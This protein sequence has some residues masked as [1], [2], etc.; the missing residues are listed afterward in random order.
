MSEQVGPEGA[1]ALRD[2]CV[3][4]DYDGPSEILY[5]NGSVIAFAPIDPVTDGHLLVVPCEHVPHFGSDPDVSMEV[6]EFAA[7]LV[8][9]MLYLVDGELVQRPCNVITSVGR[10]ATQTV[11]HL[12]VHIVPRRTGDGLMLPWSPNESV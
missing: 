10:A 5:D 7:F 3:F 2:G 11:E 1:V 12:H 8:N 6:M 4:C 9:N